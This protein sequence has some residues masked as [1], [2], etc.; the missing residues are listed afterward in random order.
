VGEWCKKTDCWNAVRDLELPLSTSV[1]RMVAE[2]SVSGDLASSG[3]EEAI[4]VSDVMRVTL[5]EWRAMQEWVAR[6]DV[7]MQA[8]GI[9]ASM[10]R[11]ANSGWSRRPT[12]RQARAA[13]SLIERWRTEKG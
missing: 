4:A 10:Y 2:E 5:D 11:M 3:A 6:A 7:Y 9:I 13:R 12:A 8:P 1:Q